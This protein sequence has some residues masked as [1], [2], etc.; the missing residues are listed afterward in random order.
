MPPGGDLGRTGQRSL[1][2]SERVGRTGNEDVLADIDAVLEATATGDVIVIAHCHANWWASRR[3]SPI[4]TGCGPWWP[5]RRASPTWAGRSPTGSRRAPRWDEVIEAPSGWE[6]SNRHAIVTQHRRWIEF[7]FGRQLVEPHSTKQYEDAV[8]WALESTGEVL[9]AG[10]DGR[11]PPRPGD[12]RGPV[13]PP[14]GSP[15]W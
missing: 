10:E 9:A 6:L 3:R 4:P 1:R 14:D 15:P 7:F 8:G 11:G 5:S 13:S 12:G 2:P